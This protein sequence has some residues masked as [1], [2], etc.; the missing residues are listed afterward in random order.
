MDILE[1]LSASPLDH[2]S[3]TPLYRQL[4][5][6][7]LQ[8][9]AT[10]ALD[11]SAPLPTEAELC[12][13]LGL[14]RATVR[15]CFKDLVEE[16]YVRRRRGQGTFVNGAMSRG[17]LDALFL[18]AS[19]SGNLERSGAVVTSRFLGLSRICASAA[20]AR[21]LNVEEGEPLWE[22]NR[23][24]LADGRPV[25]HELAFCPVRAL[26]RLEE[27]D[28]LHTSIYTRIAESTHALPERT[29]ERIEAVILDRREASLLETD[30]GT[31]AS[32][33]SRVRSTSAAD[34]CSRASASPARTASTSR[35]P[36]RATGS[37]SQ[38]RSK[39]FPRMRGGKAFAR[40]YRFAISLSLAR[41]SPPAP[42]QHSG[43]KGSE[44]FGPRPTSPVGR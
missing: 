10:E 42:R 6:R 43:P 35:L 28:L 7:I 8:L 19:T 33:C 4:K 20:T 13:A 37:T 11:A 16:G 31:R 24:R 22:V 40:T 38:R 36:T 17:G 3:P 21:S 14:S 39:G 2:G 25:I 15:R 44:P 1:T 30:A 27:A 23:L 18:K 26:P 41:A 32:A 29:E 34:H 5:H 9:I 12:C